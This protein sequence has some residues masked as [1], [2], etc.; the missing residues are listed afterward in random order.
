MSDEEIKAK[1]IKRFSKYLCRVNIT[2]KYDYEYYMEVDY[3][4]W[5]HYSTRIDLEYLDNDNYV[6]I[7]SKDIA[8]ALGF[9]MFYRDGER[10]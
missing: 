1:I 9:L 5:A 6:K 3:N 10:L 8:L 2:V 4:G 7:M